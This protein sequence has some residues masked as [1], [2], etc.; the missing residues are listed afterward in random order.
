VDV[1]I[2][3]EG[4]HLRR[5]D[6]AFHQVLIVP[7]PPWMIEKMIHEVPLMARLNWKLTRC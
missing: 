5:Q 2:L 6:L 3:V 7:Q 1:H 4:G